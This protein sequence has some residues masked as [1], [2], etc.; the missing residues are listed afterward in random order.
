[1]TMMGFL[2]AGVS[3]VVL[4]AIAVHTGLAAG[5]AMMAGL[6]ALAVT[7]LVLG[8]PLVRQAVHH[9]DERTVDA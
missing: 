1:M 2:G 9:M 6:Y 8:R 7:A 5:F 4:P 3:T